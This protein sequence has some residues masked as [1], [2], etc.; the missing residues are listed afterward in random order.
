[1]INH[2]SVVIMAKDAQKTIAQC[3]DALEAFEEVI[4]YLNDCSDNTESIAQM[5][6]N[7][8][9][10]HGAFSGFGETKNKASSYASNDWILSLDADEVLNEDFIKKLTSVS[11][12]KNTIYS[13]FRVNYYQ[14]KEIKYCWK[15]DIIVRLYA[16][17][18]TEFT[19]AKVH[20]KIQVKELSIVKLE[21]KV[22]HFPYDDVSSFIQKVDMYST[23]FAQNNVGKK[24]SSPLKAILNAKYSFIKTYILRRGF[25]DGYAG[26]LIA[27]SHMV[28]NFYK[29]MKLYEL[30]NIAKKDK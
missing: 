13:I 29:Y 22:K 15:N 5:Y 7:V 3:L 19:S 23:L 1:M 30:N 16:Q 12:D 17:S 24:S 8:K 27:F 2:I 26:L 10:I 25:L 20:E 28:V 14:K 11:L 18:K 21:G 9:I 6:D 4:L